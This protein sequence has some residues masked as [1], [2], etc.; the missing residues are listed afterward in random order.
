M[1]LLIRADASTAIGNGHVMRCLAIAQAWQDA[2]GSVYFICAEGLPSTLHE[3]LIEEDIQVK[4]ISSK[5]GSLADAQETIAI[6]TAL[7]TKIIVV[8][9]YC[10]G[11][12][13]QRWL[14]DADLSVLFIDDNGH[15][16]HYSADWVLNQNIHADESLYSS[17]EPDTQ[18][19]LDTQYSLLRREFWAWR[20]QTKQVADIAQNILVTM[21]GGDPDNVTQKVLS[22]IEHIPNLHIKAVVGG[23]NPHL[24]SLQTFVAQSESQIELLYNVK[25]MPKLMDW[26]DIA[27]SAGGSTV[28]ELCLMG[29][30]SI[31]IVTADNQ[32]GIAN[33]L[34]KAQVALYLGEL[35]TVEEETITETLQ[36][37]LNDNPLR[38]DMAER[39][40]ELVDGYGGNRIR[41]VIQ[42]QP[43]WLRHAT[44]LDSRLIWEWAND[45]TV[46]QMSLSS[47]PI[48]WESHQGWYAKKLAD[49]SCVMY[50]AMKADNEPVG[51]IRFDIDEEGNAEIGYSVASIHRGQGFGKALLK[52]GIQHV[53]T[54]PN[55]RAIVGIVKTDNLASCYAFESSGFEIKLD[56]QV[57]GFPCIKYILP[58]N[59]DT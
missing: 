22:A 56:I 52:T 19:L 54:K 30:P 23:S 49:S 16:E 14:K 55:V 20:G 7:S 34:N 31:L 39:G 47:D 37:L 57:Q 42:S 1:Q 50:I 24:A 41:A 25:D 2:G 3:R 12:D 44:A 40:R 53:A 15:A 17:R 45:P 36:M 43:L 46:R 32:I 28:W 27:I 13:Y 59:H 38:Q 48:P 35:E 21:G 4:L 26:S 33:G 11:A 58:V 5:S 6:A 8:D 29:V 51:Q 10:F 18:L 9:G